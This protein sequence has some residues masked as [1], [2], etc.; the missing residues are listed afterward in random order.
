MTIPTHT[1]K[2]ARARTGLSQRQA[3][4]LVHVKTLTWRF[5]EAGR[6]P[7]NPAFFELFKLKTGLSYIDGENV[8][9][10]NE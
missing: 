10:K 9:D 7:M 5:W 6:N 4:E 3:A 2:Q 8:V 1:I